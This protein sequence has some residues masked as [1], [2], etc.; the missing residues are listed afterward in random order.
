MGLFDE[1]AGALGQGAGQGS[2]GL[3]GA[4]M[5]L[6]QSHPGG[7]QGLVE[8][9][10]AG[11][12]GDQVRSWVG[13]GQNLPA[14]ADQVIAALGSDRV[15]QVAEQLGISHGDAAGGLASLLPQ[16][17]NHLTPNGAVEHS[18]VEEGLSLLRGRLGS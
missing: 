17:I 1:I 7:L 15:K 10:S 2:G 8:Q 14:S 11:G 12:L 4:A 3:L 13:S 18:L 16:V 9:L 6:V 5:A